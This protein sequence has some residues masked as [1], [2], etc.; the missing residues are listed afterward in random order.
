MFWLPGRT[1]SQFLNLT[2]CP[3]CHFLGWKRT[4]LGAPGLTTRSKKLLGAPGIATRSKG[5][6]RN[7]GIAIRLEAI[8]ISEVFLKI[9]IAHAILRPVGSSY[10]AYLPAT[11]L[12]TSYLLP[13]STHGLHPPFFKPNFLWKTAIP[14]PRAPPGLSEAFSVGWAKLF[15]RVRCSYNWP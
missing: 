10:L 3:L 4:L 12:A 5:A 11:S 9:R 2:Q 1:G 13:T 14:R 15:I 8:A 6:T 7:K